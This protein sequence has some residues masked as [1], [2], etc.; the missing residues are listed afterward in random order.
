MIVLDITRFR[1]ILHDDEDAHDDECNETAHVCGHRGDSEDLYLVEAMVRWT[2]LESQL[3][4]SHD[5]VSVE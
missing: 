4:L 3:V 5:T 2:N 1:A